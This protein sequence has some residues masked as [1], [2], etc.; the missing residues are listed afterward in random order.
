MTCEEMNQDQLAMIARLVERA[1][2][3]ILS[4]CRDGRF[5][6]GEIESFGDLHDHVDAN[7]YGGLCED[8]INIEGEALFPERTDNGTIASQGFMDA[9]EA[10]QDLLD[11]WICDGGLVRSVEE[12]KVAA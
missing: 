10:V 8:E 12:G 3:E 11:C 1:K 5:T 2:E 6:A 7:E 9:C 4:D